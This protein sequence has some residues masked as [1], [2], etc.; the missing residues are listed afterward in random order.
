[1]SAFFLMFPVF[2]IPNMIF[3]ITSLFREL[4]LLIHT[5]GASLDKL[6]MDCVVP[7]FGAYLSSSLTCYAYSMI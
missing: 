7:D 3:T 6:V 2:T 1:M 5:F 4:Q